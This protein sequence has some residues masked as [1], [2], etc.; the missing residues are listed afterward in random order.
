MP[1]NEQN[2]IKLLTGKGNP[3]ECG[4]LLS[5]DYI[6]R[7]EST[8]KMTLIRESE[9]KD[10]W[11]PSSLV[12]QNSRA[13]VGEGR[14]NGAEKRGRQ[15]GE[16]GCWRRKECAHSNP[17]HLVGPARTGRVPFKSSHLWQE[18]GIGNAGVECQL[19]STGKLAW[20]HW[21]QVFLFCSFTFKIA[22]HMLV[23]TSLSSRSSLEERALAE[24]IKVY[25]I[26][27]ATLEIV[28]ERVALGK[29]QSM[30]G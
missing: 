22:A 28:V 15:T 16:G 1:R 18:R 26:H 11:F 17:E 2:K 3:H 10:S 21:L 20:L 23:A 8:E 25:H 12:L 4:C 7:R 14:R 13:G 29:S 30:A 24:W 19:S 9:S 6:T 27:N 5:L